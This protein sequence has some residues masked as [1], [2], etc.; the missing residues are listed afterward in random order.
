MWVKVT[1]SLKLG[2]YDNNYGVRGGV[3]SG[4]SYLRF[5]K[6]KKKKAAARGWKQ[7]TNRGFLWQSPLLG[8]TS[9]L[10][11]NETICPH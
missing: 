5:L 9:F 2:H 6:K 1:T 3:V 11:L 4:R 7:E 8:A 10:L